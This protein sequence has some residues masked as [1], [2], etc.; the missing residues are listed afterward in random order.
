[1]YNTALSLTWALDGVCGQ[2]HAPATLPREG[3]RTN[4]VGG[5]VGP[6]T[7]LDGCEKSDPH[8]DSITGPSSP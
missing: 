6:R 4:W 1:M 5:S 8:Q 2:C 7:D 3:P